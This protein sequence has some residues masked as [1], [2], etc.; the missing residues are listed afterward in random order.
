M[1]K[2][3]PDMYRY[4]ALRKRILGVDELHYYDVYAPLIK[5][6]RVHYTYDQASRW[7]W[8]PLHRWAKSTSTI[9]RKGYAERWIDV[10]PKRQARR[11]LLRRQL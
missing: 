3:L 8:M 11:R 7:F 9:V 6:V 2:H 10:Y 5:G 1:R 4:V